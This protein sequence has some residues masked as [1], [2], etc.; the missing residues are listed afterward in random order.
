MGKLQGF[1]SGKPTLPHA[2]SVS[3]LKY[4]GKPRDPYR[5]SAF[6]REN[7]MDEDLKKEWVNSRG[8]AGPGHFNSGYSTKKEIKWDD[9]TTPITPV[10]ELAKFMPDI[11]VE[12]IQS[13]PV[14][15]LNVRNGH[16]VTHDLIHSYDPHISRQVKFNAKEDGATS[17]M[18]DHTNIS[19]HDEKFMGLHPQTIGSRARIYRYLR[20]PPFSDETFFYKRYVA[21][22]RAP[23][24]QI[25]MHEEIVD[26]CT[27]DNDIEKA[28]SVYRLLSHPPTIAVA[29]AMLDC[30]ARLRLLGDAAALF[31]DFRRTNRHGCRQKEVLSAY[32]DVAIACDHPQHAMSILGFVHGTTVDNVR[33]QGVTEVEKFIIGRHLLVWL[34]CKGYPE[35][36]SVYHWMQER[37]FLQHDR[38]FREGLNLSVLLSKY[39]ASI[40]EKDVQELEGMKLDLKKQI[41]EVTSS[42]PE[43]Q[44]MNYE[45]Q[46][47]LLKVTQL[48]AEYRMFTGGAFSPYWLKREFEKLNLPFVSQLAEYVA[49]LTTKA[50]LM[51]EEFKQNHAKVTHSIMLLLQPDQ[52]K[53]AHNTVLPY[54]RKSFESRANPN[55]RIIAQSKRQDFESPRDKKR[56]EFFYQ[57]DGMTRF[58]SETHE[59]FSNL[60]VRQ[61]YYGRN[62]IQTPETAEHWN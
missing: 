21:P 36:R 28:A 9:H 62:T 31:E 30:C 44:C 3:V 59:T 27:H 50:G 22:F 11:R 20:R 38:H 52:K 25:A 4:F 47:N 46:Q 6:R 37:N 14:S 39:F 5:P 49:Q 55:V 32:M 45:H 10:A 41:T 15:M 23:P 58:V 16:R 19:P 34:L 54:F 53:S 40:S 17:P 61:M 42:L 33:Y 12:G 26:L 56:P 2:A 48:H 35:A 60:N 29:K 13:T 1:S 7:V 8:R 24:A 18:I 43:D 57:K 51:T